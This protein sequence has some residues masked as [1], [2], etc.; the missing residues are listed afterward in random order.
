MNRKGVLSV[1]LAAGL[2]LMSLAHDS[3]AG[4]HRH[5]HKRHHH[6]SAAKK[7]A[8]I[9]APIA[10]GM[11]FGPAGSVGYQVVKHRRA[12]KHHLIHH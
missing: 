5:H 1:I 4:S 11:A 12:I 6:H 3:L 7:I 10:I 8:S 9:G 2:M